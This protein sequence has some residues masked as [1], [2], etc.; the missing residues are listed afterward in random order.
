L[1]A[2]AQLLG[3]FG[4]AAHTFVYAKTKTNGCANAAGSHRKQ[5]GKQQT[6]QDT[7]NFHDGAVFAHICS[8]LKKQLGIVCKAGWRKIDNRHTVWGRYAGCH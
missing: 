1:T 4:A 7:R 6:N 5:C 8:K 2:R 3:H